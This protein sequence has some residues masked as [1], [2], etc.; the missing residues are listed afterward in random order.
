MTPTGRRA[1]RTAPLVVVMGVSGS[2]KTTIGSALA[3]RL[4][5]PYAEADDFHP[6]RNIAK[7]SAGT[8]LDDRDRRPW[9]D[10]IGAWLADHGSGGV[11]SCS[12]LKRRYRDRLRQAAPEV[13]FVHLNGTFELIAHRLAD[14]RGHFMPAR[15]LRSQFEDL[16]P[17]GADENGATVP[18]EGT[19]EE[20]TDLAFAA[21]PS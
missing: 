13:F 9:L 17:L 14:R 16:E 5:V 15:L 4:G 1:A 19:P 2:G 21:L 12:A 3:D 18:I 10:A 11:V 7:M 8:P 6:P 20:T